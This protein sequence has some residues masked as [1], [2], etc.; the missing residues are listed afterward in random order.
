MGVNNIKG[1]QVLHIGCFSFLKST[2]MSN[3]A[4]DFDNE[5]IDRYLDGQM[6]EGE[7]AAFE[8]QMAQN[9]RLAHEVELL[10]DIRNGIDL[11]GLNNL[12]EKLKD[13][14]Y[15]PGGLHDVH[16][17]GSRHRL[18]AWMAVAA[19]LAAVLLLGYIFFYNKADHQALVAD[20]YQTYPNIISPVD[21]SSADTGDELK[22]A[23]YAYENGQ[24]QKAAMLFERNADQL[25]EAYRFYQALSY[26]EIDQ[27][28]KTI[29][30]LSRVKE[31]EDSL[32]YFPSLWYQALAYLKTDRMVQ[33]RDNLKALSEVENSYQHEAS[34]LLEE[35]N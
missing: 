31:K 17:S 21:R 13:S 22:Q 30:L 2:T 5:H 25:D 1:K 14:D 10:Q 11:Y 23:L 29:D 24:Y 27:V 16:Q 4:F 26:F 3:E 8:Q 28:E 6:E 19:S 9:T 15:D 12:K 34:N 18:Y 32:F 35:I 33:A 7:R 20:R